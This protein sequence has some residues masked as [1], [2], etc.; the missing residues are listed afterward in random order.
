MN[1]CH[2]IPLNK[3]ITFWTIIAHIEI[4]YTIIISDKIEEPVLTLMSVDLEDELFV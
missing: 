3:I 4:P 1:S 2:L